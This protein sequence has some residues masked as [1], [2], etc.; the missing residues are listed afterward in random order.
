MSRCLTQH[1]LES[2]P[3][4][5]STWLPKSAYVF[6]ASLSCRPLYIPRRRP[7]PH[8]RPTVVEDVA[9]QPRSFSS[10]EPYSNSPLILLPLC[11]EAHI[12]GAP[13]AV[14]YPS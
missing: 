5:P 8:G 6:P 13:V 7:A 10:E 2:N 9:G 11:E 12:P 4:G 3:L 14:R 1:F